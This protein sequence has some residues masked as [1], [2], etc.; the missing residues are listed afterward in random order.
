MQVGVLKC[1]FYHFSG[2]VSPAN[3]EIIAIGKMGGSLDCGFFGRRTGKARQTG[4]GLPGL[5]NFV[6]FWGIGVVSTCLLL[7]LE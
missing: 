2:I 4:L 7:G 1:R 6:E 3:E 5:N